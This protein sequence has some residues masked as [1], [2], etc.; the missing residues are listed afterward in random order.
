MKTTSDWILI[1]Q[2]LYYRVTCDLKYKSYIRFLVI[3][4]VSRYGKVIWP[5]LE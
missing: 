5:V 3:Y 4:L 1:I 2:S